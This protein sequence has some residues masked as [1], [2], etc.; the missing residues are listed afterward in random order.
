MGGIDIDVV[1]A[2]ATRGK[3]LYP[4]LAH[5]RDKLGGQDGL[6]VDD[7]GLVTGD[8]LDV[9]CRENVGN[10]IDGIAFG[11]S[12]DCALIGLLLIASQLEQFNLQG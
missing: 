2:D 9:V 3:Q 8:A 12:G 1:V 6:V 5:A 10:G 11:Q 4:Q 7:D